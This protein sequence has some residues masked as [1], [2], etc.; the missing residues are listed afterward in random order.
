MK[1]CPR[2]GFEVKD[3]EKYCPHCGL[4]LQDRYRPIKQKNK[5]MNYL[6]YV[7]IFFSFI[8]IPLLY[9]RILSEVGDGLTQTTGQAVE[10]KE[11]VNETPTSLLAS[12]DTLADFKNQFTNV[13]QMVNSITEKENEI[14]AKGAYSFDKSYNIQVLDNYNI[15]Y[16]FIYTVQINDQLS[17]QIERKYD[18]SHT[19]N[20]EIISL[21]KTGAKNFDGL[22]LTDE[23]KAIM[24]QY[25]GEEK[26]T[27]Q[28]IDEFS[29]RQDEFETKK[30]TLGHYGMGNYEGQS[31]FVAH[32]KGES[33]YSELKYTHELNDYMS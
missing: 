2:C 6:L 3:D 19:Y 16:R 1:K 21:K 33:Y 8:I 20:T 24:K 5:A 18:R 13:D 14:F 29:K 22:F 9:S 10:L 4:D 31:S 28:L 26:V 23:E 15:L 11:V 27:D 17:L 7:I 30:K 12:F 25:T 32:R